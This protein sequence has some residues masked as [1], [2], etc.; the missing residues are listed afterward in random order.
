MHYYVYIL[1]T[2]NNTA[3]YT[4]VTNNLT[5][6]ISEH[7]AGKIEGFTAKYNAHKLVYYER[8]DKI[9]YAII[10]EKQLKG[11]TRNKKIALIESVNP[12]WDE[13]SAL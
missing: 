11:W 4:G 2:V 6:R 7:K 5:R 1:T 9:E 8:F 12:E 3:L 13:L 10:R